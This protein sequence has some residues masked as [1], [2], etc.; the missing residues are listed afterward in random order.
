[1]IKKFSL[2]LVLVLVVLLYGCGNDDNN[3]TIKHIEFSSEKLVLEIDDIS[4]LPIKLNE[5]TIENITFTFSNP[6][7]ITLDGDIVMANK[8]GKTTLTATLKE[9]NYSTTIEVEVTPVMPKFNL[10]RSLL[11]VGQA[12]RI[13][14]LEG[15]DKSEYNYEVSDSSIV[16]IDDSYRAI[17]LKPGVVTLKL[18]DKN[19]PLLTNSTTIEVIHVIPTLKTPTSLLQVGDKSQLFIITE[20]DF[21]LDD[22][23]I[24]LSNDEIISIDNSNLVTALKEG[25]VTVT[26]TYKENNKVT[27]TY[28]ITVSKPDGAVDAKGEPKNG[29]LF[30]SANN[31]SATVKAGEVIQINIEGGKDNYNYRWYSEDPKILAATDQGKIMGIRE[32]IATLT[33]VS[34]T[35]KEVKGS[36][37]ITVVGKPNVDYASRM[38]EVALYEAS[39]NYRAGY[40]QDN[41]YGDWF[42][43]NNVDWCAIFV[44]WVANQSGVG[45]DVVHKFSL[46]SDGVKWFKNNNGYYDRGTYT[47]QPGDVIFFHNSK[48]PSH[49]GVVISSDDTYV[50]TVEGNTSNGV[51]KRTYNLT[52]TYILGYGNPAYPEFTK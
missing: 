41:K 23:S 1:M 16:Y 34:K 5:Y 25:I 13:D 31:S 37:T 44:S 10:S 17:A 45:V 20:D 30:I 49:T 47:P 24:E 28:E 42:E 27:T 11:E 2:I 18:T 46:V 32:G 15:K 12:V 38:V 39:L 36:I 21:T 29:P 50:Y 33:V 19:D 14:L 48:G 7:I 6:D 43:Y 22:F 9:K 52:D 26:I 3:P 8:I 35:N 4:F 40:N 51:F